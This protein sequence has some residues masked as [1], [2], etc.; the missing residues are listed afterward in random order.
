MIAVTVAAAIIVV[1]CYDYVLL[2]FSTPRTFVAVLEEKTTSLVLSSLTPGGFWW[3]HFYVPQLPD[4]TWLP[5]LV[6]YGIHRTSMQGTV[7]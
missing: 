7:M 6:L 3:D 2:S 1:H 5:W 4:A